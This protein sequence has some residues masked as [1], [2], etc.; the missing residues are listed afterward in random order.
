MATALPGTRPTPA[1]GVELMTLPRGIVVLDPLVTAPSVSPAFWIAVVAAACVRPTTFGTSRSAGPSETVSA[2][3][4]PG[5][6]VVPPTGD[7]LMIVPA[8]A[9]SFTNVTEAAGTVRPAPTIAA[10]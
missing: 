7:W 4:V 9:A 5:A 3:A 2:T 10:V 8:A 1:P 6:R